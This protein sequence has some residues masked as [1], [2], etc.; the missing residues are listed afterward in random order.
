MIIVNQSRPNVNGINDIQPLRRNGSQSFQHYEPKFKAF[1]LAA[2][3]ANDGAKLGHRLRGAAIA[4]NEIESVID[5]DLMISLSKN[6]VK[7]HAVFENLSDYKNR[8]FTA[9]TAF[10]SSGARV[11]GVS[12]RK[13][14]YKARKALQT[15]FL[16]RE[17]DIVYG[18]AFPFLIIPTF[19][20][21]EKT[22]FITNFYFL[23][24]E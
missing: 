24:Y 22:E 14:S 10:V 15:A 13:A 23:L 21:S 9:P 17:S 5:S 12:G 8:E 18:K 20:N 7:N 11:D 16:Y 2:K 6:P 4:A 19:K 1:G 3:R